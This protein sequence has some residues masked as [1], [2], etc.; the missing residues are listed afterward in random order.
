MATRISVP[1]RAGPSRIN[2]HPGNPYGLRTFAT[3]CA[4]PLPGAGPETGHN[5]SHPKSSRYRL[6]CE[7]AGSRFT[8]RIT[9]YPSAQA[10][11]PTN[12]LTVRRRWWSGGDSNS[13]PSHCE[14][15][16]LPAELP[17]QWPSKPGWL[18]LPDNGGGE[19]YTARFPPRVT[20]R[21]IPARNRYRVWRPR[22]LHPN[23]RGY[24]TALCAASTHEPAV[25]LCIF[26]PAGAA[27]RAPR[28]SFNPALACLS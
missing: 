21:G 2:L 9:L 22:Y 3:R 18:T 4:T 15:D 14:R 17:P 25:R 5:T 12:A 19:Y 7:M 20:G 24:S 26:A 10:E 28:R 13:R 16:A 6:P 27:G 1:S 23:R 8:A 11:T